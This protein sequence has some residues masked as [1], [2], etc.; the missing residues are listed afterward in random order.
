MLH[1]LKRL[2]D[3]GIVSAADK[4]AAFEHWQLLRDIMNPAK[5]KKNVFTDEATRK[6]CNKLGIFMWR[7]THAPQLASFIEYVVRHIS[8]VR[9]STSNTE[10]S[11]SLHTILIGD[12]RAVVK[13]E[14]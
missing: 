13:N 3:F 7:K 4:A 6:E 11:N 14:R 12:K 1:R 9:H 8:D 5:K 2:Y 10:R